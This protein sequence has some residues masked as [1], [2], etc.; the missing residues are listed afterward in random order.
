MDEISINLPNFDDMELTEDGT[1]LGTFKS[2]KNL[3]E[4]YDELRS[5]FTKNAME[6][7]KLKHEK[8]QTE[9]ESD[10]ESSPDKVDKAE[11]P[12]QLPIWERADWNQ[13]LDKFF[14]NNPTASKFSKEIESIVLNDEKIANSS[15]P[16]ESAWIKVLEDKAAIS[17]EETMERFAHNPAMQ[18][19]I[20]QDYLNTVKSSKTAPIVIA[21]REGVSSITTPKRAVGSL[22]E[23]FDL[24]KKLFE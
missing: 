18:E 1:P 9:G 12:T 5:C 21:S 20:I 7:A 10:K 22:D 11:T 3:K 15:A 16:L 6:L 4:A 14:A 13:N 8:T 24:A 2:V 19:R 17:D 23:A